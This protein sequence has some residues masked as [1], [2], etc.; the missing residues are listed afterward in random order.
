MPRKPPGGRVKKEHGMSD[1]IVSIDQGTTGT[2]VLVLDT[3]ATVLGRGYREITQH[4]PQPGWV[5]HDPEEIWESVLIAARAAL[6]SAGIGPDR[7]KAVGITNQRE[8]V[9]AW[10]RATG[11]PCHRAIVWQCRRTAPQTERLKAEGLEPLFTQRTGLL[12]DPYFSGTKLAWLLDNVPGLRDDAEAG[13]IAAGTI[14]SWLIWKLSGGRS[15]VTDVTNASRTLLMGLETQKWDDELCRILSV[16]PRMLPE[17]LPC[18]AVFG[19]VT[20]LSVLPEGVPVSGVAGDQQAALFGQA[21]FSPGEAKCT[22]GTGAFMLM[23]TGSK[24]VMSTHRLLTTVAWRM[25]G[26]TS[27]ALEGSAFIA[28]ALVQWLRDGLGIISKSSEIEAL[29]ASVPD[30]GGVVVVPA[31]AGLS[32]PHW[33]PEAR[34]LIRGISRATTRGH[35]ARAALVGIALQNAEILTAMEAD[36]GQRLSSLKVDGGASANNLLMQIQSDLLDCRITRP[37]MVETTALG[38]AFLAGLGAGL[39]RDTGEIAAAWR[40]DRDFVPGMDASERARV[41]E[42]WHEAVSRA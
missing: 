23:N 41:M 37:A 16:P 2:T 14:D 13:R 26:C 36:A 18:D 10:D 20:G 33:R 21:C 12:L 30:T 3:R 9:V 22:F 8:T 24:P 1:C 40:A 39:Y 38:A 28:G 11:K 5:E 42:T 19:R 15:H 27:Y 32:A 31:L 35:L 34:G 29:A 17:I 25:G 4:Y 7:V 6:D